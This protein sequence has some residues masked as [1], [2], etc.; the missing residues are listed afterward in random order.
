MC[1]STEKAV[2]LTGIKH[3]ITFPPY[4][5]NIKYNLVLKPCNHKKNPEI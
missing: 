5:E 3:S 1:L 4:I 2:K